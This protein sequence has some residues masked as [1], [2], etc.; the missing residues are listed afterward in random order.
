MKNRSLKLI[1]NYSPG[2]FVNIILGFGAPDAIHLIST[3]SPTVVMTLLGSSI[4]FGDAV[5]QK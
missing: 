5:K 2:N 3:I 4:H 1:E